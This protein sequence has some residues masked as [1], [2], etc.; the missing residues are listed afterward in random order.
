M[1]ERFQTHLANSV[2]MVVVFLAVIF[3]GAILLDLNMAEVVL[4]IIAGAIGGL[5]VLALL[6]LSSRKAAR[7][8]RAIS[9]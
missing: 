4:D 5:A 8:D 7:G 1:S 2:L 6:I 9:T 3:A